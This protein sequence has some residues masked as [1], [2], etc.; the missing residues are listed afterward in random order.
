MT[1]FDDDLEK[2]RGK[3]GTNFGYIWMDL[4]KNGAN[5]GDILIGLLDFGKK[6]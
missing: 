3:I 6:I 2:L 5:F 1:N 4:R